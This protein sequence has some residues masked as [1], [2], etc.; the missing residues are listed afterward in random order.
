MRA[1]GEFLFPSSSFSSLFLKKAGEKRS[2]SETSHLFF[3]PHLL[4]YFSKEER[5]ESSGTARF[6]LSEM[7][8]GK[9][10]SEPSSLL[11]SFTLIFFF[12]WSER[13]KE[14]RR[15]SGNIPLRGM[16]NSGQRYFYATLG[17]YSGCS[18]TASLRG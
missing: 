13:K 17:H 10:A 5:K 3:S 18:G 11:Y 9:K 7:K 1:T 14:R 4:F 15:V 16:E 8:E 2:G 12:F 6:L